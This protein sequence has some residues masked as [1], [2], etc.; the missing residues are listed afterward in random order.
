MQQEIW[1]KEYEQGQLVSLDDKPQSY[2]NRYFRRL[3]FSL[4]KDFEDWSVLDL[5][6]GTGR[7]SNF[8]A[9]KG[10]EVTGIEIAKNAL[11]LAKKRAIEMGVKVNYLHQSIGEPYPFKDNSFDLVMDITSSNSLNNAEREVYL[12]EVHRV[13]KPGGAFWVRTLSLDN[14]KNAKNLLKLFPG[15]EEHTYIM[16]GTGIEEHVFTRQEFYKL[17]QQYFD[18]K[19]FEKPVT[20]TPFKGQPYKRHFFFAWMKKKEVE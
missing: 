16:P 2:M 3:K 5:G 14:D 6:S 12:K 13:L 17:Y 4:D 9:E 20:Y 18:I 11:E 19:K 7:N 8:L 1:E 10:S 15:S